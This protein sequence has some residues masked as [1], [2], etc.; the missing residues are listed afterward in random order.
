MWTRHCDFLLHRHLCSF[1]FYSADSITPEIVLLLSCNCFHLS[2]GSL[3]SH[4]FPFIFIEAQVKWRECTKLTQILPLSV[5]L[6]LCNQER[7]QPS[8]VGQSL[9]L[10]LAAAHS[11]SLPALSWSHGCE[12]LQGHPVW[13][14]L[15]R[16]NK[17]KHV[18]NVG[19]TCQG[20][21][22]I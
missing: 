7:L 4:L 8:R 5:C 13:F 12:P 11:L 22:P 10:S 14:V 6:T 9:F 3:I 21:E 2:L 17:T 19:L 20:K 15:S 16:K 1:H 18:K